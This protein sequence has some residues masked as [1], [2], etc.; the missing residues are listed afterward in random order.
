MVAGGPGEPVVPTS[1]GGLRGAPPGQVSADAFPAFRWLLIFSELLIAA[2]VPVPAELP[3][4]SMS[5]RF[6]LRGAGLPP[7]TRGPA[8]A[9]PRATRRL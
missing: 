1:R 4:R 9:Y 5:C 3:V 8:S 7:R 6:S 2:G